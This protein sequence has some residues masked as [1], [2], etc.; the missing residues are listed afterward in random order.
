[1]EQ[2]VGGIHF[3]A[4]Y[5][6]VLR[7]LMDWSLPKMFYGYL[8]AIQAET[9][10]WFGKRFKYRC[11]SSFAMTV[12]LCSDIVYAGYRRKSLCALKAA[13]GELIWKNGAWSR[14]KDAWQHFLDIVF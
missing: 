4:L 14:G 5:A 6:V 13:T 11:T 3:V 10:H 8:Y 9:G 12:W 2:S 7:L 1:M